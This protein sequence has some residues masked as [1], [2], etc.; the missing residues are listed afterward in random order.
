VSLLL[1]VV[2]YA[3]PDLADRQSCRGTEEHLQIYEEKKK[4]FVKPVVTQPVKKIQGFFVKSKFSVQ[5]YTTAR[6]LTL[7]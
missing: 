6:H 3:L 1:Y 2:S 5:R 4:V 7:F